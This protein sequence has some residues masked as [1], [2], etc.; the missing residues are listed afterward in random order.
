[1]LKKIALVTE[2]VKL[3]LDAIRALFPVN[4]NLLMW[5]PPHF[6]LR[7]KGKVIPVYTN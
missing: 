1:M 5:K 3:V 7:I 4:T 6:S 2:A